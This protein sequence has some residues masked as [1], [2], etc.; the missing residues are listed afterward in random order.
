MAQWI[1]SYRKDNTTSTLDLQLDHKPSMEE[2]V[3][4]L[5]KWAGDNLPKGEFGD[6][7]DK[8]SNAPAQ[9]LLSHYGITIT[10]I[11]KA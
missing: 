8:R 3:Q 10:G 11:A 6:S 9:L 1:I 7:Q 5:L 2:T 4:H